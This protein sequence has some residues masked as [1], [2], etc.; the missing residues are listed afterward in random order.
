M[1]G[2]LSVLV[3][4]AGVA[5]AR[6][7][8]VSADDPQALA[9]QRAEHGQL[10]PF[11]ESALELALKLRDA[12]PS[13]QVAA[14]VFSSSPAEPL[15]RHVASFRLDAVVGVLVNPFRAADGVSLAGCLAELVTRL[16][17]APGLVLCGRELGDCDDGSVPALLAEALQRR[18]VAQAVQV[19]HVGAALQ[20]LRQVGA[21]QESVTVTGP[22]VVAV[23]NDA[24]NR[25]RHPL[26]KNVMAARKVAPTVQDL[27]DGDAAHVELVATGPARVRRTAG[28][29]EMLTGTPEQQAAA[30]AERL[31]AVQTG[32]P[33]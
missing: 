7:P 28:R 2:P 33:T 27:A 26:L 3:I 15:Q 32:S 29:C 6:K 25:L 24:R 8:L 31:R 11:D 19:H 30:L 21:V 23:T 14:V 10:S 20:V 9:R 16:S 4:L 17:P 22:T 5:D 13:V 12:D 18:F 1:S